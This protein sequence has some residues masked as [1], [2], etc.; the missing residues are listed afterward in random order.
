MADY[1]RAI[2]LD[3]QEVFAYTGRGLIWKQKEGQRQGTR[4]IRAGPLVRSRFAFAYYNRGT[5]WQQRK[6]YDKAIRNYNRAIELDPG[7]RRYYMAGKRVEREE[8]IR[9]GHHRLQP[10]DPARSRDPFAYYCR[11][12]A[13][14]PGRN[15][16]RR[17]PTSTRRSASTPNWRPPYYGRGL[18]RS[19]EEDYVR[20]IADYD[21]GHP[22]RPE[23]PH[24]PTTTAAGCGVGITGYDRAIADYNEA[25][26]LDPKVASAYFNR[27]VAR[28]DRME[29]DK[30]LPDFDEA[31]RLDAREPY[32]HY[33][34]G[35]VL[36]ATRRGG[37]ADE[38]KAVLDIQGWR[39]TCRCSGA[40]GPL[41]RPPCRP[42]ATPP[43]ASSTRRRPKCD[44]STWPYPIIKHLRGELDEAGLLAAADD[45]DQRTEARCY[46]GLQALED[47]RR[48]RRRR[49]SAG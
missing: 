11:G 27:G 28:R 43:G 33:H 21:R 47:G 22:P 35:I 46:L 26:R 20:A 14:R 4:R 6:D 36:F 2:R 5:I 42:E 37:A 12:W 31:I 45:D 13:R 3:P 41:R 8:G 18:A 38:A 15:T 44:T 9:R 16:M 32:A 25:I 48:T 40:A 17:S 23:L 1:D 30:R 10:V 49:I 7:F 34:R 39:E 24:R 19:D 29:W